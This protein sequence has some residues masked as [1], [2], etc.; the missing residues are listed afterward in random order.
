MDVV[1]QARGDSQLVRRSTWFDERNL[2]VSKFGLSPIFKRTRFEIR[3][4]HVFF[5][6]PFSEPFDTIYRDHIV[7]G[8][9]AAGWT[10]ER[11]DDVY[12]EGPVMEHVW[13]RINESSFVIADLTGRNPNVMYEV[14]IAHTVGRPVMLITQ[15]VEDIPFDLRHLR[16]VVYENSFAGYA[17]LVESMK[18]PLRRLFNRAA[19]GTA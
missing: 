19:G 15:T 8:I 18:A 6:C 10:V 1:E 11:A 17:T 7:T 4:N 13:Q 14:G 5:A 9:D 2:D 12:T 16:Y 3:L